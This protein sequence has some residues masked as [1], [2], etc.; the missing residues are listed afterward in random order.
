MPPLLVKTYP[1]LSSFAQSEITEILKK[2]AVKHTIWNDFIEVETK[3]LDVATLKMVLFGRCFS[4]LYWKVEEQKITS[5]KELY[6]ATKD[7]LTWHK[8]WPAEKK[9]AVD[10][11]TDNTF[12]TK[13]IGKQVGQAIVDDFR[14]NKGETPTVDLEEPD[15]TVLARVKDATLTLAIDLTSKKV[16][17]DTEMLNQSLLRFG[18]WNVDSTLGEIFYAGISNTAYNYAK[19]IAQ[20]TKISGMPFSNLTIINKKRTL[21]LLRKQWEKHIYP[22][23]LCFESMKQ[24][25]F[26]TNELVKTEK[27][28][29]QPLSNIPQADVHYFFTNLVKRKPD[30]RGQKQYLDKIFK[31][32]TKNKTYTSYTLLLREDISLPNETKKTTHNAPKIKGINTKMVKLPKI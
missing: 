24:D 8:T 6:E 23:L 18:E 13:N 11:E 16:N 26:L 14:T 31:Q 28:K 4:Q 32:I 1:E 7:A 27:I 10:P 22:T 29:I 3:Q 15:I 30:K 9:F 25:N 5:D 12:T 17:T 2:K 19:N 21:S 20:R